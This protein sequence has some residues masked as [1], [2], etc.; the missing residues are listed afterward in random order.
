M[1]NEKKFIK[2]GITKH[3]FTDIKREY[4]MDDDTFRSWSGKSLEERTALFK[5]KFPHAH[6]T[7]YK[8]R[9]LYRE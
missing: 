1:S 2:E 7:P 9:K 5:W 3:A 6:I 4:L 8:L